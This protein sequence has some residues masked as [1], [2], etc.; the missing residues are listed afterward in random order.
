MRC[1]LSRNTKRTKH[2][3]LRLRVLL[4]NTRERCAS[5]GYRR[6]RMPRNKP[7]ERRSWLYR[8]FSSGSSVLL[9]TSRDNRAHTFTVVSRL[10]LDIYPTLLHVMLPT[11]PLRA[12]NGFCP[13]L[14]G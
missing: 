8:F 5:S 3:E 7:S 12:R 4:P 1:G 10:P 6:V 2:P 13:G 11:T 14:T 9:V